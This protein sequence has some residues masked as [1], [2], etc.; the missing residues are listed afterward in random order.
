MLLYAHGGGFVE[1]LY[2]R[3]KLLRINYG[4][5]QEQLALKVGYADKT[6]IAK[7]EA[8][9]V[10]LPQS[11]IIAFAKALNTTTSYLM[12]GNDKPQTLAAHFDGNEY[13]AEEL[14]EIKQFAEFVK[15]KRK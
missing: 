10:D 9:K 2:D 14:E 12:D 4:Y 1:T 13:T 11:K 5:S 3:I 8:G 7:I 15:A 6:S